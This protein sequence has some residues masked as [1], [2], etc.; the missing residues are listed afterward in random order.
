MQGENVFDVNNIPFQIGKQYFIRTGTYH[1]MGKLKAVKWKF[2]VLDDA[3]W[4]PDSGRFT[5]F[6]ERGELN[7]VEPI[8]CG[9]ANRIM[10]INIDFIADA[11]EWNHPLPDKQK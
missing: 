11:F 6:L 3:S 2:L 5:Q 9:S 4:I 10:F 8:R 7:E 1:S